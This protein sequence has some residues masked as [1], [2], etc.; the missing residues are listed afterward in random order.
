MP[1]GHDDKEPDHAHLG[2]PAGYL[3]VVV[4]KATALREGA[5]IEVRVDLGHT[6]R[7]I[8]PTWKKSELKNRSPKWN[9][10]FV[11]ALFDED[12]HGKDADKKTLTVRGS[13]L[14]VF[15]GRCLLSL[16]ACHVFSC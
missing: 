12:L 8:R 16:F 5:H 6:T 4:M 14:T 13:S 9:R 7:R 2:A 15:S 10:K 1:P 3:G 11:L